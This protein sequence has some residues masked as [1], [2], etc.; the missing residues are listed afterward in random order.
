MSKP[1]NTMYDP[2]RSNPGVTRVTLIERLYIRILTEWATT[3]FKWVGLPDT[4]DPRFLEQEL[5]YK[6]MILFYKD[7]NFNRYLAVRG[8]ALGAI[9]MYDNPTKFRTIGV[10]GYQSVDLEP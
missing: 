8:T 10:A 3:R 5:F 7:E 4:I 2:F 1:R 9:N 6:S